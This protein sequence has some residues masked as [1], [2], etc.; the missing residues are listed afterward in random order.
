VLPISSSTLAQFHTIKKDG[1]AVSKHGNFRPLM[2]LGTR[3][4]YRS[5]PN[6]P[7]R[8]CMAARE[9]YV[10][11]DTH[12]HTTIDDAYMSVVEAA[13]TAQAAAEA[14]TKGE[15]IA[16]EAARAAAVAN[17][18]C[19]VDRLRWCAYRFRSL[20]WARLFITKCLGTDDGAHE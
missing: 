10:S 15:D 19:T 1:D 9:P 3:I 7:T 16:A 14:A 2:P 5:N 13:T 20:G 12:T 4:I 18:T 11:C 6:I 8:P 17:G